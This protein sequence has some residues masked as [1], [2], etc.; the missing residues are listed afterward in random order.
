MMSGEV[1]KSTFRFMYFVPSGIIF[2]LNKPNN[3]GPPLV[4]CA[5]LFNRHTPSHLP[6]PKPVS[7]RNPKTCHAVLSW[8]ALN[9]EWRDV[10]CI[11]HTCTCIF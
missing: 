10:S 8:E 3:E 1:Y 4:G 11:L 9:M 5:Q 6:Y 2:S 7:L